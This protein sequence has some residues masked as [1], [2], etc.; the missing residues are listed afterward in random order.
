MYGWLRQIL[1]L[2]A[3]LLLAL[4][5]GWC[6]F[7]PRGHAGARPQAGQDCC[8]GGPAHSAAP[9]RQEPPAAPATSCCCPTDAT[10]PADPETPAADPFSAPFAL[11]VGEVRLPPAAPTL[12]RGDPPHP[13]SPPPR[14]LHCVW[15]C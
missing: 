9:Y 1:V 11:P 7:T 13:P 4:P 12:T 10:T 2:S 14:L 3:A 15:L 5:P 6:C 8:H